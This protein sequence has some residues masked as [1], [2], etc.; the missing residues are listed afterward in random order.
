MRAVAV[1]AS[2]GNRA[3]DAGCVGA[4]GDGGS[5][6]ERD[7]EGKPHE[8]ATREESESE[9]RDHGKSVHSFQK[10]TTGAVE[11]VGSGQRF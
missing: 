3:G 6:D 10:K 9:R 7:D 1:A 5:K 8:R 4:K 11:L 2:G